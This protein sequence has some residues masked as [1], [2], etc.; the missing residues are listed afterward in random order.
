MPALCTHSEDGGKGDL[1][2]VQKKGDK[3]E[4]KKEE[5]KEE[6]KQVEKEVKG[7][8]FFRGDA[9]RTMQSNCHQENN[10]V[11]CLL[12]WLTFFRPR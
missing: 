1:T 5:E 2:P 7:K 10:I 12:F 3:K 4:E 11:L 8:V 9:E 6:E